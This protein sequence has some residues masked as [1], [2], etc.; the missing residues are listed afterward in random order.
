M[1]TFSPSTS[2]TISQPEFSFPSMNNNT[3]STNYQHSM[4]PFDPKL[5][6]PLHE[7]FKQHKQ[8]P[9]VFLVVRSV[10]ALQTQAKHANSSNPRSLSSFG[11]YTEIHS[12]SAPH[13]IHST[14]LSNPTGTQF[15]L[16]FQ[17]L[18][19]K[20]LEYSNARFTH[21]SNVQSSCRFQ[22]KITLL[23][24]REIHTS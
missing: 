9:P 21:T 22:S 7:A 3:A 24:I 8:H 1:T 12:N 13:I 4:S 16:L 14:P 2:V 19:A 15:L 6:I 17:Q 18:T 5:H 11:V 23:N 10:S 20:G